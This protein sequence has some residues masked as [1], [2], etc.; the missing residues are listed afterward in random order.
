MREVLFPG[1]TFGCGFGAGNPFALPTG[2]LFVVVLDGTGAF[3]A[4]LAAASNSGVESDESTI[5]G[6]VRCS[7][8]NV[9]PSV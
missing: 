8:V 5:T 6:G 9:F 7:D 1:N 3:A 4:A 2:P